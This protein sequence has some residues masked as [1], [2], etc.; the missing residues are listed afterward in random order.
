[1]LGDVVRLIKEHNNEC[2]DLNKDIFR[3]LDVMHSQIDN[4]RAPISDSLD[5][6]LKEVIRLN[7][8]N[9]SL[10]MSIAA[11]KA[12][13]DARDQ[14][15]I[16]LRHQASAHEAINSQVLSALQSINRRLDSLPAAVAQYYVGSLDIDITE[17]AFTPDDRTTLDRID[18]RL[19]RVSAKAGM[20]SPTR[21]EGEKAVEGEQIT[22]HSIISSTSQGEP[23]SAAPTD[24]EHAET[25]TAEEKGTDH[26]KVVEESEGEKMPKKDKGKTKLTPDEVAAEEKHFKDALIKKAVDGGGIHL[27]PPKITSPSLGLSEEEIQGAK[28]AQMAHDKDSEL[29]LEIA[30]EEANLNKVFTNAIKAQESALEGSAKRNE[31]IKAK[32]IEWYRK[33]LSQR[34][35]LDKIIDVKI[36]RPSASY[37]AIRLSITREDASLLVDRLDS[38]VQFGVSELMEIAICLEKSR[39]ALKPEVEKYLADVQSKF[40]S[41][42]RTYKIIHTPAEEQIIDNL[43][44]VLP[45]PSKPKSK[46]KREDVFAQMAREGKVPDTSNLDL[47]NPT[48]VSHPSTSVLS[49]PIHGIFFNDAFG[50]TCFFRMTQIPIVDTTFLHEIIQIIPINAGDIYMAATSELVQWKI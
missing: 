5:A 25:A 41:Y 26:P 10:T 13:S 9:T 18:K 27:T 48:L 20:S 4:L 47:T 50:Q 46:S 24:T 28:L 30:K 32:C 12:T 37:N 7:D 3:C 35:C 36:I 43:K 14:D 23:S 8:N 17:F 29:A 33:S 15:L 21:T 22:P 2:L 38:L 39:S 44:S 6:V 31:E 16:N 42:R 1:M 49:E 11:L 19:G 34:R 45:P 40:S